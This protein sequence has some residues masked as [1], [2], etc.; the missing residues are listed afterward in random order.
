METDYSKVVPEL[1]RSYRELGG[2]N[3]CDGSTLPSKR[4]GVCITGVV[5]PVDGGIATTS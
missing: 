5:L 1:L 3:K 4:A 2:L